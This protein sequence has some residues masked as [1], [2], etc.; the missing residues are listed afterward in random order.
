MRRLLAILLAIPLSGCGREPL[1][2]PGAAP[3]KSPEQQPTPVVVESK[4]P[5]AELKLAATQIAAEP[6]GTV[7]GRIV[8]KGAFPKRTPIIVKK[9]H[10]DYKYC[11]KAGEILSEEWILDPKTNGIKNV[12]VWLAPADKAGQLAIHPRRAKI[13]AGEENVVID[14]PICMFIPNSLALREGQKLT[15]KNSA[16]VLHAFKWGGNPDINAGASLSIPPGGESTIDIKADKALIIVE[17]GV[18]PWMRATIMAFDHPY[19]AV[20]DDQG[21]FEIKD[22][23]A[24]PCRLM[25]RHS[26][27]LY[28]GGAKGRNGQPITI[29]SGANDLKSIDFPAPPPPEQ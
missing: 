22:A 12:F 24:G 8:G 19:F 9:D 17:C 25:V 28:L 26:T 13:A 4:D 15:V 29:E 5:P 3:S 10:P 1:P 7:K 20:T 16:K 14:Q 27:G 18:H 2:N 11:T 21:R 6:W 23:P